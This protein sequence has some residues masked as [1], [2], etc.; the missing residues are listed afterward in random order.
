[1]LDKL[2]KAALEFRTNLE[3]IEKKSLKP[4]EQ[5]RAET[6]DATRKIEEKIL[7][8][9]NAIDK[10]LKDPTTTQVAVKKRIEEF[11]N[12]K[13]LI[14]EL[15]HTIEHDKQDLLEELRELQKRSEAYSLGKTQVRLEELESKLKTVEERKKGLA[16]HI[17]K[18]IKLLKK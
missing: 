2:H 10:S 13:T 8:K 1:M 3:S 6:A 4:L 9:A 15:L 5:M 17:T 14:E 18:F 12:R 7:E 11:L 16:A